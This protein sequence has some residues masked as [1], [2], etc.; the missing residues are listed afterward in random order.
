MAQAVN[1]LEFIDDN[2]LSQWVLEETRKNDILD[3]LFTNSLSIRGNKIVKN[4]NELSDH[5]TVIS[6]FITAVKTDK[7]EDPVNFYKSNI[8]LYKIKELN[9][10]EWDEVNRILSCQSQA[11]IADMRAETL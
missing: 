8:P 5:N 9:D 3:L 10:E 1:L 2:C 7:G 4:S 6:T 11:R